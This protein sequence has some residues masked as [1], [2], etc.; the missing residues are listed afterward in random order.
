MKKAEEGLN[1]I[2]LQNQKNTNFELIQD[3]SSADMPRFNHVQTIQMKK[4]QQLR[5]G[6]AKKQTTELNQ[7]SNEDY[8][9]KALHPVAAQNSSN[10]SFMASTSPNKNVSNRK[11]ISSVNSP[12]KPPIQP[13]KAQPS[14]FNQ[15]VS[16]TR[17]MNQQQMQARMSSNSKVIVASN[18]S[19]KNECQQIRINRSHDRNRGKQNAYKFSTI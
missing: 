18:P 5:Q 12:S 15:N 14:K 4:N 17:S 16:V 3:N 7:P 6:K 2:I 9:P 8:V 13:P 11:I 19:L 1:N 10:Q